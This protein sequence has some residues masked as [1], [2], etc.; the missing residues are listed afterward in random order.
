LKEGDKSTTKR[1]KKQ[2][3]RKNAFLKSIKT[4]N[5]FRN[6]FALNKSLNFIKNKRTQTL[7][8][9]KVRLTTFKRLVGATKKQAQI[10]DCP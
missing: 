3:L 8:S 4:R 7:A 2:K 5:F 10:A 1:S 9:L 6:G